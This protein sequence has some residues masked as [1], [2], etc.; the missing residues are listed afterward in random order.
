M[1][2]LQQRARQMLRKPGKECLMFAVVLSFDGE[3][4]EDLA[5][6]IEHVRDEVIPALG[7][8]TACTAGGWQTGTQAGAWR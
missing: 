8:R 5:A 3:S 2:G 1:T 4:G 6:G 7:R